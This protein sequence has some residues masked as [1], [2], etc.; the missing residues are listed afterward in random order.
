MTAENTAQTQEISNHASQKEVT[1][2]AETVF[3]VGNF[4]ITNSLINS[5]IAVLII[6]VFS[7]AVSRKIKLIPK[8]IQ[9]YLEVTWEAG[10]NLANSITGSEE[11]SLKFLPLV[12]PLFIFI[13]INNWIA[14]LP[15]L[16]SINYAASESGKTVF[17]PFFRGATADLNTT[18]ALAIMVV[19]LTHI[20]SVAISGVWKHLNK[21][22]RIN[23]IL[24]IPRKVFK[25][26]NYTALVINPINFFVGLIEI[27]GEM[28]KVVSLAF[29]LFGNVFA[30]EVLLGVMAGISA[31]FLPI[32][33]I[34]L[35]IVVGLIQAF[36][37][38]VLTLTFL[39]LMTTEQEH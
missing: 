37:F 17:V 34:F 38:S 19:L 26:K 15:G 18:L 20:F 29:R 27:I 3:N 1:P 22:I 13:L 7:I 16:N 36:I 28:A 31:Y 2:Y 5:W 35:E 4:S 11:K 12:L 24:E 8:G 14:L 25:E 9:S 23:L 32:P 30:G 10:L 21:F 33:F 6:V 39:T